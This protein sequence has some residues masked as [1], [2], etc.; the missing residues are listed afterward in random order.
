MSSNPQQSLVLSSPAQERTLT[1]Q[2]MSGKSRLRGRWRMVW[3]LRL[4]SSTQMTGCM[5]GPPRSSLLEISCTSRP[6]TWAQIQDKDA[7]SLT[8]ASPLCHLTQ[9]QFQDTTLLQTMGEPDQ[10]SRSRPPADPVLFS[11]TDA[12]LTPSREDSPLASSRDR[13]ITRSSW[14]WTFSCLTATPGTW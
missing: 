13:R 14:S 7:S 2:L 12:W 9:D 4:L 11:F 10:Q 1:L 6:C 8:I 3:R 5:R